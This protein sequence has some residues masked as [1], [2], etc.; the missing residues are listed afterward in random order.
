[1]PLEYG[2]LTDKVIGA[3]VDVHKEL[4]PGFI[5]SVYENALC[6]ELRRRAV[7]FD[8][9]TR[10]CRHSSSWF[11]GFL[12][13]PSAD[14][15]LRCSANSEGSADVNSCQSPSRLAELSKSG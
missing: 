1:M 10:V 12:R 8:R 14:F 11:P 5:E 15:H 3:A 9:Q 6:V 7:S 2:G 4:G 13:V